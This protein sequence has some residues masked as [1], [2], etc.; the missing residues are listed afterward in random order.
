[1]RLRKIFGICLIIT[2]G[3]MLTYILALVGLNFIPKGIIS[4]AVGATAFL[5]GIA[6]ILW[7]FKPRG[8]LRANQKDASKEGENVY[9]NPNP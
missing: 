4:Y 9:H 3:L 8:S 1:V 2:S 5:G 7:G 6:F